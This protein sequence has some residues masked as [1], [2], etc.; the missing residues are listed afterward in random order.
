MATGYPLSASPCPVVCPTLPC[1]SRLWEVPFFGS[2]SSLARS[3]K[4]HWPHFQHLVPMSENNEN[5]PLVINAMEE[6]LDT[7]DNPSNGSEIGV[8]HSL[9]P[10]NR[11][12]RHE[13]DVGQQ[14][15]ELQAL[16]EK[17][18]QIIS[19]L[20]NRFDIPLDVYGSALRLLTHVPDGWERLD[21]SRRSA[22]VAYE[23]AYG[24][25]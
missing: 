24:D 23:V 2:S 3:Q 18:S 22:G 25:V 4:S 16:N 20:H 19:L 1:R 11:S 17:Q 21:T 7:S 14:L 15:G 10:S 12:S 5:P 8:G 9:G 6:A 13:A